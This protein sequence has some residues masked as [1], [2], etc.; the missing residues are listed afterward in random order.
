MANLTDKQYYSDW[1]SS[2]EPW[3]E[4]TS[5]SM[6]DIV[7][8]E[9]DYSGN[10]I[11]ERRSFE[12]NTTTT[13]RPINQTDGTINADWTGFEQP[14]L[15]S[16]QFVTL[17]EIVNNYMVGY[18]DD[19]THGGDM[20]RQKVEFFAQ[21]AV[22]DFS[23][24]VFS[25]ESQEF[26]PGNQEIPLWPMPQDFVSLV[27][28]SWIDRDGRERPMTPRPD[29]GN[30]ESPLQTSTGEY[31]YDTAGN[32]IK[33]NQSVEEQ[34]YQN[35]RSSLGGFNTFGA[36]TSW[37]GGFNVVGKR[38]YLDPETANRNGTYYVNQKNGT[39]SFD[40]GA[41]V[42]EVGNDIRRPENAI[43]TIHY[44][45]DGL[46]NDFS[47]IKVHKFAEKAIYESIYA[48]LIDKRRD[49]PANEKF[50]AMKK[51]RAEKRNAKLRLGQFSHR[52]IIQ[53]L[54]KQTEWIKS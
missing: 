45:S 51:A 12:A 6:G 26:E 54:R 37:E 1:F 34:R 30:P 15:G 36:Y 21:R 25:V 8:D 33:A 18:T 22:Q 10:G 19:M 40:S 32:I 14:V 29:S 28:I 11:L 23:Y 24:D 13:N 49:V 7:Y 53:T 39:I 46:S 3:R 44:V 41:A 4:G 20:M 31:I 52:E 17:E 48:E 35:R 27:K 9:Y 2:M 42:F 47:Q 5:Y 38:Y 16:G 43:I 50:K